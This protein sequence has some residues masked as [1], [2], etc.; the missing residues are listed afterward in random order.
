MANDENIRFIYT[1]T[2]SAQVAED[3]TRNLLEHNLI[4][5][6][7][8]I[9]EITSL[10][11]WEGK[12]EK[13]TETILILKTNKGAEKACMN[14]LKTIHPATIP[15]IVSIK[16]EDATLDFLSW[17]KQQVPIPKRS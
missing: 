13:S 9:P 17:V 6:A 1:T 3:I 4:A 15:C 16:T 2:P 11:I 5:C 14:L 8:L 10:Y 7:N 12:I